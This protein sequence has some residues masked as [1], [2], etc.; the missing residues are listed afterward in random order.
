MVKGFVKVDTRGFSAFR[1]AQRDKVKRGLRYAAVPLIAAVR[2]KETRV[3]TGRL[4]ASIR[5]LAGP[6]RYHSGY[7]IDVG[8][9]QPYARKISGKIK[10]FSRGMR[11]AKKAVM[12]AFSEGYR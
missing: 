11:S 6:Y 7:A 1:L 12:A 8:S 2:A 5:L 10:F 9:E 4:R 3:R